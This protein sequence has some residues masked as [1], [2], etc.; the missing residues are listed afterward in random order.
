MEEKRTTTFINGVCLPSSSHENKCCQMKGP[1][2]V[3]AGLG[4]WCCTHSINTS[5]KTLK[6]DK[7]NFLEHLGGM[8]LV[9][10]YCNSQENSFSNLKPFRG[11]SK[12]HLA[13][14]TSSK[15]W[16]KLPMEAN[17]DVVWS[18]HTLPFLILHNAFGTLG[19]VS[20]VQ[21]LSNYWPVYREETVSVW[22]RPQIMSQAAEK[23]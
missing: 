9:T 23:V 13:S 8:H 1:T 15:P 16:K 11:K 14:T 12:N 19:E 21:H 5:R 2:L 10:L 18:E 22:G 17:R 3:T 20:K 4:K 6:R 7:A